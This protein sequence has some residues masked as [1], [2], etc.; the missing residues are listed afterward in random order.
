MWNCSIDSF[1]VAAGE[2]AF[3]NCGEWQE[4]GWMGAHFFSLCCHP[5]F[6]SLPSLAFC[7]PYSFTK[8]NTFCWYSFIQPKCCSTKSPYLITKV[9]TEWLWPR[10]RKT[11]YWCAN[12]LRLLHCVDGK[13]KAANFICSLLYS[14]SAHRM[15]CYIVL[16]CSID[17]CV[18]VWVCECE[19][20]CVF[21]S[22]WEMLF[23]CCCRIVFVLSYNKSVVHIRMLAV[24]IV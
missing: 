24:Y 18:S 10:E 9:S 13:L 15:Y 4:A 3:S 5:P 17:V 19:C 14:Y 20:V 12:S 6:F 7:G 2:C 22:V 1:G 16:K 11:I 8:R 23:I 21:S